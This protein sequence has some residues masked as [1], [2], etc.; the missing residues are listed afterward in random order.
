MNF[1]NRFLSIISFVII[2]FILFLAI[3]RCNNKSDQI[4]ENFF[5]KFP[6]KSYGT[7]CRVKKGKGSLKYF[8]TVKVDSSNLKNYKKKSPLGV[9]F[10]VQN[11]NYLVFVDHYGNYEVNDK[12]CIGCGDNI[13][14][15][16]SNTGNLKFE[17]LRKNAMLF[18][19]S[20]PNK[21]IIKLLEA[22][23]N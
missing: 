12:I 18:N 21:K 8:V 5:R 6:L 3:N 13:I 9:Y 11:S 4:Q 7:I 16:N 2:L 10:A 23:C 15:L 22:G 1:R 17:K 20:Q 19:V 14:K